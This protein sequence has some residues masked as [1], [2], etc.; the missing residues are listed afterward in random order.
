VLIPAPVRKFA[1]ELQ[2][3]WR[4]TSSRGFL[5][6]SCVSSH[7][8]SV[9]FG[10]QRE[11]LLT[12]SVGAYALS[13]RPKCCSLCTHTQV[14]RITTTRRSYFWLDSSD[15]V[16]LPRRVSP[17]CSSS[18]FILILFVCFPPVCRKAPTRRLGIALPCLWPCRWALI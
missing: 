10:T 18:S 7:E 4:Q 12:V 2:C 1:N 16:P 15:L 8:G 17:H 5:P 13:V 6:S 11:E 3:H 14:P 9:R